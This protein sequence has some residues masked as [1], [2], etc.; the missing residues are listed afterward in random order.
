MSDTQR[1]DTIGPQRAVPASVPRVHAEG[2]RAANDLAT[3]DKFRSPE[4]GDTIRTVEPLK[5]G[6]PM[7]PVGSYLRVELPTQ[8]AVEEARKLVA[9]RTWCVEPKGGE[10]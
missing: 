7:H 1:L 10:R 4:I 6:T 2:R 8:A 3:H 9:A 5:V